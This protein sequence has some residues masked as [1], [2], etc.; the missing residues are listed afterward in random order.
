MRAQVCAV[1]VL[2]LANLAYKAGVVSSATI[3]DS[4]RFQ[5]CLA[6][7]SSCSELCVPSPQLARA[8][9]LGLCVL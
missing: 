9:P 7:V 5:Y 8:K 1:A 2:L 6:H 3:A 4:S